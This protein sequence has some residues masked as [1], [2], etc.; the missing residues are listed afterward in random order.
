MNI[1]TTRIPTRFAPL[2]RSARTQYSSFPNRLKI[3]FFP[4]ASGLTA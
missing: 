4:T 1:S 3:P 2:P